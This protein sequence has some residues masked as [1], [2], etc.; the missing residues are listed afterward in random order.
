MRPLS[1]STI[2]GTPTPMPSIAIARAA[3]AALTEAISAV[4]VSSARPGPAPCVGACSSTITSPAAV[5]NPAAVVVPPTS[6]PSTAPCI[7]EVT[8]MAQRD[9]ERG[10]RRAGGGG[11]EAD[12]LDLALSRVAAEPECVV[13]LA[14]VGHELR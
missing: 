2:P 11:A 12:E 10:G 5:T 13:E 8:E 9:A 3:A 7:S 6:T 1:G 4:I 14:G